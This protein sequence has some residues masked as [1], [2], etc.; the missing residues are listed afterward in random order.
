[1]R[2]INQAI[3]LIALLSTAHLQGQAAEP[4]NWEVTQGMDKLSQKSMCLLESDS[5]SV[6]DGR[7]TTPMRI[8]FNGKTFLVMTHSKIDLS[9]PQ[10]GLH[11][12]SKSVLAIDR[13]YK[14]TAAV[15]ESD[16][17]KIREQF[18]K[19]RVAYIALGFWPSWPKSHTVVTRFSLMGFHAAYRDYLGCLNTHPTAN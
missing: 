2:R 7:T 8:V 11:V 14:E 6:D 9:Y 3:C 5:Q 18:I 12:D 16:A 1:M 4:T 15:F 10:L 13:V 17:D 19:G